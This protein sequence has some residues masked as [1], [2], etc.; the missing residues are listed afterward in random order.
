MKVL[1]T[2]QAL[3]KARK[4]LKG[5]V[6]LV[7]TMGYLHEGHR[8]LMALAKERTDHVITSIFVNPKQ[9]GPNEDL[10][11]YPRDEKGDLQSCEEEGVSLVFL[12]SPEEI[13]PP[14]FSTEVKVQLLGDALCGASRP[15][16]FEGVA[17]VVTKLFHLT[18]PDLAIFGQKDY[19]QAAI[20]NRLVRDLHLP[21]EVI[22][23]P[24]VREED[25]L[26]M[27][28]RN[29]YLRPEERLRA[30]AL[31]QAL[32]AAHWAYHKEGL[33]DPQAFIAMAQT[34]IDASHAGEIDYINCVNPS[35]IQPLK[36]IPSLE[37]EGAVMAIAVKVGTAR[38]IDNLR[39]DHPLPP[40]LSYESLGL[41]P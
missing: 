8:S 30:V 26:A 35:T 28:S 2:I 17:T 25:G 12:P 16:H 36:D 40:G 6:G 20:I 14:G 4:E 10:D 31:S 39:L 37:K 11:A 18:T 3:R 27:S 1:R 29:R 32:T 34:F 19:Q 38:L 21:I 7:P 15:G 33:R 22:T 41:L 9:F 5:S 13:Y 23:A 24:T